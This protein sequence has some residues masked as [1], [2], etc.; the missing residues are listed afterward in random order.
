LTVV[1][2][3][4]DNLVGWKLGRVISVM[5]SGFASDDNM[6]YLQRSGGRYIMGQK[7]KLIVNLYFMVC[8]FGKGI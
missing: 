3:V 4:K 8:S 2:K 1:D 7:M 6:K 5:D